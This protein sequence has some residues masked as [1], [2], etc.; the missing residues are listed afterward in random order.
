MEVTAG[1]TPGGRRGEPDLAAEHVQAGID[2]IAKRGGDQ[3]L[4][5]AASSKIAA[6]GGLGRAERF[7]GPVQAVADLQN[8]VAYPFRENGVTGLAL[9]ISGKRRRDSREIRAAN[10]PARARPELAAVCP[11]PRPP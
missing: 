5:R 9:L 8:R 6:P 7:S 4:G 10:R 11:A 1:R 2:G 3:R